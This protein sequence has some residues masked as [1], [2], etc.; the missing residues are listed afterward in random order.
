MIK[1]KLNMI[2]L[3]LN[4]IKLKLNMIKLKLSP[5]NISKNM[6]ENNLHSKNNEIIKYISKYK[7]SLYNIIITISYINI[8]IYERSK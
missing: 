5:K 3:K 7:E 6:I 4:M 1:L 2:K 8:H